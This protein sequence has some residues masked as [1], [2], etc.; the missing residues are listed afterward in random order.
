MVV[1]KVLGLVAKVL[2]SVAKVTPLSSFF[3][4]HDFGFVLAFFNNHRQKQTDV[5]LVRI[6]FTK[7]DIKSESPY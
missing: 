5:F 1:A 6:F 7:L 4:C 2:W 3:L